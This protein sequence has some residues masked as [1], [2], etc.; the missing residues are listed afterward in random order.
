MQQDAFALWGGGD[1]APFRHL[2][3]SVPTYRSLTL[4]VES[5]TQCWSHSAF[6]EVD[7]TLK[8]TPTSTVEALLTQTAGNN[9]DKTALK[10][11]FAQ[12][13]VLCDKARSSNL[14]STRTLGW[15]LELK[16]HIAQTLWWLHITLSG[17][18]SFRSVS[19]GCWTWAGVTWPCTHA[20]KPS[21]TF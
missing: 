6:A 3:L 10:H 11:S 7:A 14:Q 20:N 16:V 19:S 9:Q 1:S 8:C 5:E 21:V 15:S 13:S 17:D 2:G 12:V 4:R 18:L